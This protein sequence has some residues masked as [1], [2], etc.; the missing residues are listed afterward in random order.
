[1]HSGQRLR[2]NSALGGLR[3]SLGLGTERLYAVVLYVG[4]YLLG[5]LQPSLLVL[6]FHVLVLRV[7]GV[8]ELNGRL[9]S[10]QFVLIHVY[11]YVRQLFE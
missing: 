7:D 6:G 11:Q 1:M 10:R 4:S 5:Q 9:R 3:R 2:G 8:L